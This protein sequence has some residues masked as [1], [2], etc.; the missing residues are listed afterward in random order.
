ME[1]LGC[2]LFLFVSEFIAIQLSATP[3]LV[4]YRRSNSGSWSIVLETYGLTAVL[5][6]L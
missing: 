5:G 4:V 2:E 1:Q 6:C 3:L